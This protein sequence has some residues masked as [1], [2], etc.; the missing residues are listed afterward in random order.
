MVLEKGLGVPRPFFILQIEEL[1]MPE[2]DPG[3]SRSMSSTP[4]FS[5]L[6]QSSFSSLFSTLLTEIIYKAILV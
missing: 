4:R 1:F 2:C 3:M 5:S 6:A